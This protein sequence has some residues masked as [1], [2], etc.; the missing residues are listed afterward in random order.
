MDRVFCARCHREAVRGGGGALRHVVLVWQW[1]GAGAAL[2]WGGRA[3]S[4]RG[5]LG[6][7]WAVHRVGSAVVA[8][9]VCACVCVCRGVYVCVFVSVHRL[10]TMV[11]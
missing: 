6:T 5:S 11:A 4:C 3:R 1:R 10:S 7:A 8:V 9:S 2:P